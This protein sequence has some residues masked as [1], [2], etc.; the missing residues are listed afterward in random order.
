MLDALNCVN[1]D[2]ILPRYG[3]IRGT[4][5]THVSK[6]WEFFGFGFCSSNLLSNKIKNLNIK[7]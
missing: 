4:K 5:L 6:F 1:S 3:R 7:D 2:L